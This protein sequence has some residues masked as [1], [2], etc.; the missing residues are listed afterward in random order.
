MTFSS[1]LFK[2][3]YSLHD[4]TVGVNLDHMVEQRLSV[5]TV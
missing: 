2:G 5:S 3:K 4:L 1:H